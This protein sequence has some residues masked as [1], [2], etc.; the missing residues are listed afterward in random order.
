MVVPSAVGHGTNVGVK[1]VTGDTS[2]VKHVWQWFW[3]YDYLNKKVKNIYY[4]PRLDWMNLFK[5]KEKKNEKKMDG[6][7]NKT[8]KR[9]KSKI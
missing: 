7:R 4:G 5:R 2:M 1:E 8:S 9:I 3:G 6:R